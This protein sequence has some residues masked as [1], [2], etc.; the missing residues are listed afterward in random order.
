MNK[1][2][3]KTPFSNFNKREMIM[4]GGFIGSIRNLYNMETDE[5][6]VLLLFKAFRI[7]LSTE[8]I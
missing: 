8:A 7:P 4:V 6:Y 3:K 2:H 1:L 5:S